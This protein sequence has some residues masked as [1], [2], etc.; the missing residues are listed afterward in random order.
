M[1]A[2]N[3]A[4]EKGYLKIL[5]WF[6]DSIYELKYSNYTLIRAA[7]NDRVEILDWF[8]KSKYEFKYESVIDTVASYGCTN[9]LEWFKNSQYKFDHSSR[10]IDKA[11]ANG[12]REK[13]Q[14]YPPP[15]KNA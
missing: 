1:Y 12:A 6:N 5:Q 13:L 10:A 9:I 4:V 11:A 15:R 7:V 8:S 14:S 3:V 2:I